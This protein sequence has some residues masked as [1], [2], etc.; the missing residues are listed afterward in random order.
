MIAEAPAYPNVNRLPTITPGARDRTQTKPS[1]SLNRVVA[2][3]QIMLAT[4]RA[5]ARDDDYSY[6]YSIAR[7]L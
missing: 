7:G 5:A 6:W 3:L 1:I 2:A 4:R